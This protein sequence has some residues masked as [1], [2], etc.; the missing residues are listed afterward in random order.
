MPLFLALVGW[1]IISELSRHSIGDLITSPPPGPAITV[2]Q[3]TAIVAGGLIV[4]A[5]IT[6]DMT[7]FNRSATDVVKQTVVGVTLG[8]FVIGLAGVLLAH[9]GGHRQHRRDRHLVRR[10]RRPAHRPDRHVEDQRLE[11]RPSSLGLVNFVSTAFRRDLHRVTTTIVLGVVGSVLA[12]AGILTHF[13][14]FLIRPRRCVPPIAGIMIAEY[15][16]V[17]QWRGVLDET[18]ALGRAPATAPRVVPATLVVWAISSAV[19]YFATWGIPSITSL[20]LSVVLYVI[21]GKVGLVRGAG[22]A[23]TRTAERLP[24][25]QPVH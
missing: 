19:G 13:T 1:S 22:T 8:E 11:P 14:D 5:I 3:G 18:R 20:V 6:A 12:A 23:T 24:E 16:I 17:K 25:S 7:R 10:A 9:A 4:G 21:A 15:F 2:G